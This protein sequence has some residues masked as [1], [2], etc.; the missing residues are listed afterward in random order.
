MMAY[1]RMDI[2]ATYTCKKK[3][4]FKRLPYQNSWNFSV[5]NVYNRHNPYFIFFANEGSIQEGNLKVTAKQVSL[6]PIL[7]SVTWNFNF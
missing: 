2:S 7:P 6:F 1:H 4:L 3:K 5:Y